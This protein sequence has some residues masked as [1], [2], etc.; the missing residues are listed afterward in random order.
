M[1]KANR[2]KRLPHAFDTVDVN[3]KSR[4]TDKFGANPQTLFTAPGTHTFTM[5]SAADQVFCWVVGGGGGGGGNEYYGKGG[6]GYYRGGGGGQGGVIGISFD[7]VAPGTTFAIVVGR[8]GT[9]GANNDF[10]VPGVNTTLTY[11]GAVF[12]AR[13]G[14]GG[15]ETPPDAD[16]SQGESGRGGT[17]GVVGSIPTGVTASFFHGNTGFDDRAG[18]ATGGTAA[19]GISLSFTYGNGGHGGT[20]N[21]TTSHGPGLTGEHGAVWF[22]S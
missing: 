10:G 8:G 7:N 4:P 1:S 16:A 6:G 5:P 15:R 18:G 17:C 12:T 20:T 21:A 9:C 11:K 22:L 2:S 3:L 14:S 19:I 13:G